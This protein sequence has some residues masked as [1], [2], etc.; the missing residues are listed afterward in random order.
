MMNIKNTLW[1]YSNIEDLFL[2]VEN[3]PNKYVDITVNNVTIL[4]VHSAFSLKNIKCMFI[5][6]KEFLKVWIEKKN[7]QRDLQYLENNNF[8]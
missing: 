7:L 4:F 8:L 6:L 5:M 2:S 3:I 1:Y